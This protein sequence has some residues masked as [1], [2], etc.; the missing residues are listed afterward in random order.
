LWYPCLVPAC[1]GLDERVDGVQTAVPASRT[2]VVDGELAIEQPI[3]HREQ[4]CSGVDSCARR[5]DGCSRRRHRVLRRAAGVLVWAR[6]ID[7][8]NQG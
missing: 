5:P 8:E 3:D 2:P 6:L 7:I 4:G 1:S